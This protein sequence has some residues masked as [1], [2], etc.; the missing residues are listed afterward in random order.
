MNFSRGAGPHATPLIAGDRLFAASTDKQFFAIEK[1][2]GKV[3]WSHNFV[4][5]YGAPPN[6]MRWAVKPGYATSPITYRDLVIAM[7]GGPGH[8]VVAFRQADGRLAWHSGDFADDIAPASPL[9]ITLEGEEQL[10][11]TSGDGI[12]GLDPA[13]GRI[14]WSHRFPTRSGVNISSPVWHP[15]DRTLFIS[16]AY[17]G[18]ARLLRLTRQGGKT[19]ANEVWFNTRMRVHFGN[20]V[21]TDSLIVGS[22]GDFGPAFLTALDP[23]SGEVLWQDRAFLKAHFIQA[24]GKVIVF[25]EDGT[26]AL[27][28]IASS[29]MKVLARASVA[30][31]TSWTVPTLV[32]TRLY[33]RDRINIQALDLGI[34]V[35]RQ[36]QAGN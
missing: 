23:K 16:A 32:G 6:Q 7:S 33:V 4:K 28:T 35:E 24:D 14:I 26:L 17:D 21:R 3:L 29:G 18:G 36:N 12:H 22:S 2:S 31:A 1:L 9:L 13:T 5:E 25:D 30:S 8:A 34:G 10:V 15:A 11:V 27:A 20:I 19:D